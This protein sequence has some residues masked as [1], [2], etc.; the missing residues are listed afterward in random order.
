MLPFLLDRIGY[1]VAHHCALATFYSPRIS[2][3]LHH[4]C[5]PSSVDAQDAHRHLSRDP[6]VQATDMEIL[7]SG[8]QFLHWDRNLSELSEPGESEGVLYSTVSIHEPSA[9]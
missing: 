8:E 4:R 1:I 5:S 7:D 2:I 9:V 6:G 3:I